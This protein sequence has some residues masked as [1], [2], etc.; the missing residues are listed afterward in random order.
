[1]GIAEVGELG[2]VLEGVSAEGTAEILDSFDHDAEAVKVL[3]GLRGVHGLVKGGVKKLVS[4]LT[5]LNLLLES[6]VGLLSAL[7]EDSLVVEVQVVVTRVNDL[8]R[9]FGLGDEGLLVVVGSL[10][11]EGLG[12]SNRIDDGAFDVANWL[13]NEAEVAE[14]QY[15]GGSG[16]GLD[17]LI[18]LLK[19]LDGDIVGLSVLHPVDRK[20]VAHGLFPIKKTV[21]S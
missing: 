12:E 20:E 6:S 4:E 17:G 21:S 18:L 10:G 9:C 8:W 7:R 13:T 19:G 3:R 11:H 5:V 2:D 15:R 1:M 16:F 14:L